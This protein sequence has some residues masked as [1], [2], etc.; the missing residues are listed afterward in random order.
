[1]KDDVIT[2]IVSQE[3]EVEIPYIEPFDQNTLYEA[4]Q[5]IHF[6]GGIYSLNSG[7]VAEDLPHTLTVG[8]EEK[9]W[10]LVTEEPSSGDQ[11]AAHQSGRTYKAGETAVFDGNVP[12]ITVGQD[13]DTHPISENSNWSTFSGPG[14]GFYYGVWDT[15][16]AYP[17]GSLVTLNG[18]WY[19]ARAENTGVNPTTDDVT[20]ECM[21]GQPPEGILLTLLRI[22]SSG[23]AAANSGVFV[24]P[25]NAKA[26]K[27][28][29][30]G[31]GGG[32]GSAELYLSNP[33]VSASGG[34]GGG[35]VIEIM[36]FPSDFEE[37]G[38]SVG[39]Q[40]GDASLDTATGGYTIFGN[41]CTAQKGEYGSR[42]SGTGAVNAAGGAGGGFSVEN[43][44][45]IFSAR[46][47]D[48]GPSSGIPGRGGY[49]GEGG[50][51]GIGIG[52]QGQ[53]RAGD[54][55]SDTAYVNTNASFRRI[56]CG[57]PG[58]LISGGVSS[59]VTV[60]ERRGAHGMLAVAVWT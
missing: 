25:D 14:A 50:A 16:V 7:L 37:A 11:G 10:T 27:V 9:Q 44:V 53:W 55:S 56:G 38:R 4:E 51:C 19:I 23:D 30:V 42:Q 28:L 47:D 18:K 3:S 46:G 39:W 60:A 20:W 45:S 58:A 22:G 1:M 57:S 31:A 8:D 59:M 54:S 43:G 49:A 12:L 24:I 52:S 35:G 41:Y 36:A 21:C 17:D 2:G 13:V 40:V 5:M 29:C 15:G 34:G 26:M 33:H 32:A 48:G 6:E